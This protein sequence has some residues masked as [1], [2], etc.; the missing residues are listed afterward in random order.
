MFLTLLLAFSTLLPPIADA[1]FPFTPHEEITT[2]S[3]CTTSD[4]DFREFR[5]KER[6]PYCKRSVSSSEKR[7]IYESYGVAVH[8]RKEYTIDHFIPLSLG[9][10]N[11]ANNLWPEH[12]SVKSLRKNLEFELFQKLEAGRITQQEAVEAIIEAKFNPPVRNPAS[13][14]FCIQ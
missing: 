6:I 9:G 10:T 3:L 1:S 7:K 12:K 11:H 2:G 14:R 8:C 13:H 4:Q 5:Y